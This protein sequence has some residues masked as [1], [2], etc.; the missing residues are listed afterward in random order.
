M[1]FLTVSTISF[2]AVFNLL[3]DKVTQNQLELLI[4]QISIQSKN[5]SIDDLTEQTEALS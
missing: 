3:V 5:I 2:V 4:K 1:V